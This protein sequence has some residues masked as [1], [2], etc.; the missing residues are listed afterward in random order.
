MS[1]ITERLS[2]G[3]HKLL[4]ELSYED[5]NQKFTALMDGID[6]QA[7]GEIEVF[8]AADQLQFFAAK[9]G[10]SLVRRD[11]LAALYLAIESEEKRL[12]QYVM[13]IEKRARHFAAM[14]NFLKSSIEIAF[15]DMGIT[16]A[17]GTE[18][19]FLMRKCPD[20]MTISN[21]DVLPEKY[22]IHTEVPAHEEIT[23]NRDLLLADLQAGQEIPGASIEINRRSLNVR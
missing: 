6:A 4:A 13:R 19:M 3:Q 23:V 17:E 15:N 8:N 1:K 22:L 2:T 7:N 10:E 20:K 5:L 11:E 9:D 16:R 12:R 14:L 21:Q 18:A